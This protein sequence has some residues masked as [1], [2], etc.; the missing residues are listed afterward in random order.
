MPD[1]ITIMIALIAVSIVVIFAKAIGQTKKQIN[2]HLKGVDLSDRDEA[3]KQLSRKMALSVGANNF[4]PSRLDDPVAVQ[5]E[6]TPAK[7][8]GASFRTHNAVKVDPNRLEF[9]SSVAARVFSMIFF[10]MGVGILAGF[11]YVNITQGTL[12]LNID[13]LFPI[14]FG[15]LFA[16]IGGCL[17]YFATKPVVFDKRRGSY[18][19]GRKTPDAAHHMNPVKN[20]ARIEDIHAL[21]LIAERVRGDKRSYTS[22]ELN[23]VLNDGNR[24]NVVDHGDNNKL[25]EDARTLSRFLDKPVWDA[26][27]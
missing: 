25:R 24:I 2:E 10:L 22:Y 6:W 14:L 23:L 12:S 5:T 26:T 13:T 11:S 9:R 8:G 27:L 18:W 21:Q 1:M 3:V 20:F 17:F 19:K 15:L 7:G 4:D 16:V